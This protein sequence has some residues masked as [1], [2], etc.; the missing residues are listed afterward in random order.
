M[1]TR[2]MVGSATARLV[3]PCRP[4]RCLWETVYPVHR[5]SKTQRESFCSLA[6]NLCPT[7][8]VILAY[9]DFISDR[10]MLLSLLQQAISHILMY[11]MLASTWPTISLRFCQLQRLPDLSYFNCRLQRLSD[12]S[13][14]FER[15]RNM[16]LKILKDIERYQKISKDISAHL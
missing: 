13:K 14:E 2:K 15:Y 6:A 16:S 8:L 10:N 9:G 4:C 1:G 5:C 11:T 7:R 3:S 12:L